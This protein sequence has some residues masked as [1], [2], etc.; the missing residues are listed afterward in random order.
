MLYF[1][2]GIFTVYA[3]RIVPMSSAQK[4]FSILIILLF[5]NIV[6]LG[7]LSIQLPHLEL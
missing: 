4:A 3:V 5:A 1:L 7:R 2:H 6:S